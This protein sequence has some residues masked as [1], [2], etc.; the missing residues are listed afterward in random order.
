MNSRL[1]LTPKRHTYRPDARWHA[2]ALASAAV[3]II[4]TAPAAHAAMLSIPLEGD[5]TNQNY[6]YLHMTFGLNPTTGTVWNDP[7]AGN[8]SKCL[9]DTGSS[10]LAVASP[11]CCLDDD[12]PAD[13]C[14][15]NFLPPQLCYDEANPYCESTGGV[16]MRYVEGNWAGQVYKGDVGFCP[17]NGSIETPCALASS[18]EFAVITQQSHFFTGSNG[19]SCIVGLAY[20]SIARGGITPYFTQLVE[21]KVVQNLF[22][23]QFCFTPVAFTWTWAT[24]GYVIGT[25]G[26]RMPVDTSNDGYTGAAFM[27]WEDCPNCPNASAADG[28]LNNTEVMWTPIPDESFYTVTVTSMMVGGDP[29]PLD[30]KSYNAPAKSIVD[31]GTTVLNLPQDVFDTT[32]QLLIPH[33]VNVTGLPTSQISDFLHNRGGLQ[34]PNWDFVGPCPDEAE[35]GVYKLP[36][37]TEDEFCTVCIDLSIY[38]QTLQ[39]VAQLPPISIGLMAENS[40][41]HEFF[42]HVPPMQ[43]LNQGDTLLWVDCK[44]SNGR[45]AV[46]DKPSFGAWGFMVQPRHGNADSALTIGQTALHNTHV[47]F[48]VGNR[49]LGFAPSTCPYPG[50]VPSTLR[51]GN[52]VAAVSSLL[53]FHRTADKVSGVQRRVTLGSCASPTP[54]DAL[55]T[56]T[57]V[58]IGIC[59]VLFLCIVALLVEWGMRCRKQRRIRNHR[60]RTQAALEDLDDEHALLDGTGWGPI[61]PHR[62]LMT[63]PSSG[64]PLA[65]FSRHASD[66]NSTTSTNPH[67]DDD[68]AL[69]TGSEAWGAAGGAEGAGA[70]EMQA[71]G[72]DRHARS[73]TIYEDE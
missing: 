63:P 70:V 5:I 35:E 11:T 68:V 26:Q 14:A 60:R 19:F 27:V 50:L 13:Q 43:Y 38:N 56:A 57:T 40:T 45:D 54:S 2:V 8:F 34:V 41:E 64:R 73:Y 3:G 1:L 36:C 20:P 16:S 61:R 65:R 17:S 23:L 24:D 53:P 44:L 59:A 28:T 58:M 69:L 55:S 52:V 47:T 29:L 42:L 46:C 67:G 10:N 33:F 15:G 49:R 18:T 72:E 32:V 48:D 25:N 31:S 7:R 62:R 6:Y 30:C 66:G 37:D 51:D 21:N 4:L 12:T 22:A 9:V 39:A 71:L